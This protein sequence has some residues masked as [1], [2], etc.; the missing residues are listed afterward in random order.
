MTGGGGSIALKPPYR[1]SVGRDGHPR[2]LVFS[3]DGWT[4]MTVEMLS[5]SGSETR[6]H[7]DRQE[8]RLR[9][10][11]FQFPSPGQ[12]QVRLS[13]PV[14]GCMQEFAVEVVS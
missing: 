1:V 13:D 12:W 10:N 5:P 2:G 11:E 14:S 6:V 8:I 3:G 9:G 7:V 4:Q